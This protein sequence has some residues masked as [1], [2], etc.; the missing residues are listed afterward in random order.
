MSK[1]DWH[2][3]DSKEMTVVPVPRYPCRN[4]V[5]FKACGDNM[6]REPCDG[7]RTKTQQKMQAIPM[8]S[9]LPPNCNEE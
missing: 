9:V 6:R 8:P 5:Y 7:R 3:T 4:C 2:N 1:T